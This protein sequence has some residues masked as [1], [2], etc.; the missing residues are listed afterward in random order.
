MNIQAKAVRLQY[1]SNRKAEIVLSTT[2]DRLDI[3]KEQDIISKGKLLAVEIKQYRQKRSLDANGMLWAIL[4]QIAEAIRSTK[5]EVYLQM[6]ERYGQFTH[7]I[8]K[9][10]IVEKVKHE[11]RTVRELG[12]VT[13]NGQTGI[14]LQCYFGSHSYDTKEFSVLLNGVIDEARALGIEVI[15]EE[16]KSLLLQEW[17]D[18]K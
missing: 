8:V 18:S 6:L 15:T 7:I 1:D 4:Q 5:D 12:E 9:P 2:L 3:S 16:E 14:Q 13:V 11:W 10:N 17:G